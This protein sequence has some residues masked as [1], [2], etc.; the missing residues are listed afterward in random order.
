MKQHAINI[1]KVIFA[2]MIF[3]A[4]YAY[5]MFQGGFVSW[6][7]FYSVTLLLLFNGLLMIY[8]LRAFSVTRQL[9]KRILHTDETVTITVK[10]KRKTTFPFLFLYVRDRVPRGWSKTNPGTMMFFSM[11]KE[12][13][14]SYD[15]HTIQRGEYHFTEII[16]EMYDLF[17][18]FQKKAN[19]SY[20]DTVTVLPP[21][22]PLT[23]W[24]QTRFQEEQTTSSL[25]NEGEP[26]HSIRSL[27][28]YVPGDKL[29]SV[30]WKVTARTRQLVTK[31]FE[32]EEGQGCVLIL[33]NV[34]QQEKLFEMMV[35]FTASFVHECFRKKSSIHFQCSGEEDRSQAKRNEKE[36]LLQLAVVQNIESFPL[37]TQVPAFLPSSSVRLFMYVTS[38]FNRPIVEE[39]K[40]LLE[41]G[42]HVAIHYFLEQD[43]QGVDASFQQLRKLGASVYKHLS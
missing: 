22:Y 9:P 7:L 13:S 10:L 6:F 4:L 2:L 25:K 14:F 18:F 8:P 19:L 43:D 30:D 33:D 40:M 41:R 38:Q 32:A 23:T 1:G 42:E 11:A 20:Q 28:E 29:T 35:S 16:I 36:I 34:G 15:V 27:R 12:F 3:A 31:E 5:A 21:L 26:S 17:G 37:K 24:Y 39:W